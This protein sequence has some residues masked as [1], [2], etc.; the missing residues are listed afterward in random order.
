MADLKD[1]YMLGSTITLSVNSVNKVL[2]RVSDPEP[3][4]STYFLE[5]GNDDYTLTFK[6]TVPA[7]RGA[8][9]ESHLAR[10]DVNTYDGT[11]GELLRKQ[12][13]WTVMEA[14]TGRQDSTTLGYFTQAMM[15]W[16]GTNKALLLA[17]DN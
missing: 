6:H 4:S 8:S 16:I 1:K 13:C 7:S 12:S 5:D 3:F 2:V 11:S 9:K 17:R 15:T 10:L 14:S